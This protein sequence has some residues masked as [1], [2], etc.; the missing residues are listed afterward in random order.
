M[1]KRKKEKSSTNWERKKKTDKKK[2][3]GEKKERKQNTK[4]IKAKGEINK[5]IFQELIISTRIG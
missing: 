3:N 5:L 2:T 4:E 1:E